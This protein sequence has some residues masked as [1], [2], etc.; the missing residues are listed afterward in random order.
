ML[1]KVISCAEW[2]IHNQE[3]SGAWIAFPFE[4]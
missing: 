4:I 3:E 1:E 2:A